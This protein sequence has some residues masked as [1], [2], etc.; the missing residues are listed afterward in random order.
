MTSATIPILIAL[1]LQIGLGVVVFQANW[2]RRSNQC[3]L[4]LSFVTAAW[5]AGL[6]FAVGARDAVTAVYSIRAASA[7]GVCALV[8]FTLLRESI[9]RSREPWSVILA[10]S[11]V[12]LITGGGLALFSLTGFFLKSVQFS[13]N[14]DLTAPSP[15]YWVPG[16][17]LYFACLAA[18]GVTV[19]FN[20]ARDVRRA[21]GRERFELTFI[22][23][24]AGVTIGTILV[25]TALAAFVDPSHLVWFAPFRAV[26]FNLIIAYGIATRKLMDVGLFLRRL[27]SYTLLSLYLLAL[28][29][30]V[31]WLV[32]EVLA[33]AQLHEARSIAHVAAGIVVAFAMAPARGVSRRLAER[34]FISSQNLDFRATVSKA[35]EILSSIT[36]LHDLLQRFGGTIAEAVAA[37]RV[38]ILLPARG[39]FSTN[40]A[41]TQKGGTHEDC[42]IPLNGPIANY[43]KTHREPVVLDELL[44]V[45]PTPEVLNIASG[46]NNL[47]VAVAM[48]IFSR[49]H[50]AGI[51]L[52]GPRMSGRVYGTVEQNALQVLCGQLAI[53]ID[54]AQLFTE[55]QNAKI[56]NE[57]LLQ[58][59]TTGV[60][61]AGV[62][63]RITVFNNEAGEIT[64]IEP[65]RIL[66]QSVDHLPAPIGEALRK[67]LNM[68]RVRMPSTSS[69]LS[70]PKKWWSGSALPFSTD[71][72]GA[73]SAPSWC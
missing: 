28:Y 19:I 47:N 38:L 24:A 36:T 27:I 42:R 49:E 60:I 58:N 46:L 13:P 61:A 9:V 20:Y 66:D 6:Y 55:V 37:E 29:A 65:T 11:K 53:A 51:M 35:A 34:L 5:L 63:Q 4:L 33:S 3:F 71:R 72:I 70:Q 32:G 57:T 22:L 50:L 25:A 16:E 54:N 69:R 39:E 10:D 30:I 12:W 44:R 41:F 59:L 45:R 52:L 2:H 23:I 31:W 21:A 68:V 43:L 67:T 48:G 64:G 62:D 56:Y 8:V 15:V 26:L 14:A 40:Y 18:M 7:A 1:N 73:S 17:I